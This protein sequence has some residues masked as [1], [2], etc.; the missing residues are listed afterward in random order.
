[1]LTVAGIGAVATV[2]TFVTAVQLDIVPNKP[3]LLLP[4]F[5][6]T[7]VFGQLLAGAAL[8][9]QRYFLPFA[10]TFLMI[11]SVPS[12]GGV[13]TP[14]LLPAPFRFIN[15]K[16]PLAQG[17]KITRSVAY[18]DNAG[19]TRPV[20]VLTVWA[21]IAAGTV[22]VA[23]ARQRNTVRDARRDTDNHNAYLV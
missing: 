7:Q 12:S 15:D 13:V 18:F 2:S 16:L 4:Q 3:L 23:R 22:L 11:L 9:V 5:V 20:V 14:D 8:L 10:M 17:V 19:L 1:V 6:L 21:A